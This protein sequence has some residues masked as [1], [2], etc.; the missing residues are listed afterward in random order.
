[1][2]DEPSTDN[3]VGVRYDRDNIASEN[4]LS[5]RIGFAFLPFL[6]GRTVIRGGVGFFYDTIALNVAT[7][8]QFQQR[9]ISRFGPDGRQMIAVAQ[10][11]RLMLG[12]SS[13]R[14]PRSVNWNVELDREWLKNLFVRVGYQ[15]RQGRREFVSE[16]Y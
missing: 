3:R 8:T 1:M 15:Q 5:P 12:D 9:M 14:T 10:R 2:V 6:D 7:F 11:Q 16:P 4:N 13:L